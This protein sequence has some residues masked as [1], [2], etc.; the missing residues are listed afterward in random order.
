M[1]LGGLNLVERPQWYVANLRNPFG[2][3]GLRVINQELQLDSDAPFRLTGV[4]VFVYAAP[5]RN[6]EIQVRFTKADR[7]WVQKFLTSAQALNPFDQGA[8]AGAGGETPPFYAYFSPL[9]SNQLYPAG[10]SILI[11]FEDIT[12]NNLNAL[13]NVVFIG[14]KLYD[15][16]AIWN[17]GYPKRYTARPY[18]YA[19][20]YSV[21]SPVSPDPV[22]DIP[23]NI[24][25]DADFV[26][27]SG[28][29]TDQPPAAL[30]PIAQQIL[31][32][33]KFRDWAGKYYMNDFV[34]ASLIFGYNNQQ[35]P[36]LLYPEIYIPKNQALYF[37]I[38]GLTGGILG[39]NISTLTF[40]GM[41]V[42]S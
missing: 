9:G 27:R 12:G 40:N 15:P 13:V 33:C 6:Q 31:T 5:N 38:D 39:A 37:D 16:S 36:G 3:A 2:V 32:T 7:T 42:Y 17:P 28:S 23:L 19:I 22:L 14:T 11:D 24:R 21:L 35:F 34:P 8:A 29:Q 10:G 30:T 18:T 20:Q 25:P 4:A 26:W 1:Q 41:K